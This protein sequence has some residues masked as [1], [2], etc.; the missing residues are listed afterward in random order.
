[1]I[2]NR[3]THFPHGFSATEPLVPPSNDSSTPLTDA[4]P[5]SILLDPSTYESKKNFRQKPPKKAQ[6]INLTQFEKEIE[7][8][9]FGMVIEILIVARIL[10]S[11]IREDR[12][13]NRVLPKGLLF[14]QLMIGM[15]IKFGLFADPE[16][17]G[18]WLLPMDLS[19]STPIVPNTRVRGTYRQNK[20]I[21]ID[22]LG[23]RVQKK[24]W[25]NLVNTWI[26][27]KDSRRDVV[28]RDGMSQYILMVLR[29][30]AWKRLDALRREYLFHAT[31]DE[32]LQFAVVG[33]NVGEREIEK[34]Q[35][36]K[37]EPGVVEGDALEETVQDT[38]GTT[39]VVSESLQ[40]LEPTNSEGEPALE[41]DTTGT[42]LRN[43]V[44]Q[45]KHRRRTRT[46]EY[47]KRRM[48]KHKTLWNSQQPHISAI[49]HLGPPEVDNSWEYKL[50]AIQNQSAPAILFNL[51]RIFPERAD[52]YVSRLVKSS[53]AVAV[54]SS[55]MPSI[56]L[57][58][59]LR[60]SLYL[61]GDEKANQISDAVDMKK[62]GRGRSGRREKA[63]E[64]RDEG[65]SREESQF[66]SLT[67]NRT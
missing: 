27:D 31:V 14:H 60:L 33:E 36:L 32:S 39:T 43:T 64:A 24:R 51:R 54:Q 8:N 5:R 46:E 2:S 49:L 16:T 11:P 37:G 62:D 48:E 7:L 58:Q 15:L 57:Y 67:E 50:I 35:D 34:E 40:T 13:A 56:T 25:A 12:I 45:Q 23:G 53:N 41:W 28:W 20:K 17:D 30:E 10:G 19:P 63:A 52:Y 4:L 44:D 29:S 1:M 6:D 65:E 21:A 3:K 18:N 22:E 42:V 61:D 66:N 59:M 9:P 47:L 38:A 55:S 26:S